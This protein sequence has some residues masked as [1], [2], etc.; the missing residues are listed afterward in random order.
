MSFIFTQIGQLSFLKA[1]INSDIALLHLYTN[2]KIPS[3]TD[4][5]T[6]Y[7]EL[8]FPGYVPKL[9]TPAD[10]EYTIDPFNNNYVAKFPQ[11]VFTFDSLVTAFGFYITN[12][13]GSSLWAAGR[14]PGAPITLIDGLGGKIKINPVI[15]AK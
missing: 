8:I 10:W 5:I 12:H 11:Q 9:L 4:V 15:G 13:A 6:D 2:D 1:F 3:K 7:T 14:F